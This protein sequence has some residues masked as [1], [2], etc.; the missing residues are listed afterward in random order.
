L[1]T[2]VLDLGPARVQPTGLFLRPIGISLADGLAMLKPF[3]LVCLL[4]APA[5]AQDAPASDAAPPPAPPAA[6]QPLPQPAG[7]P[8]AMMMQPAPMSLSAQAEPAD[9]QNSLYLELGGTSL[10]YSLNYERFL[11]PDFAVRVGF[12]YISVSA[13][14]TSGM[15]TESATAS[16]ATVP[17][18][19]EYL[20]IRSGS[21]S[22]EL[23]AG[24]NFMYMS[25][26]A[27]TFE[28]T[29]SFTGVTAVPAANIGYRYSD[30]KGG[31]VF[32]A[33]YTPLFV[34]TGDDKTVIS[35]FGT[36]F[37]YRF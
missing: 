7:A 33:G 15:S 24:I 14:A 31:F 2:N 12:S 19:G 28:S 18:M 32:R 16:W 23:G 34:V 37:G 30:P 8:P 10:L 3:A 5:L 25:G 22:L 36:S 13:V 26:H 4:V 1:C 21:H 20:G 17:L 35:W 9:K 11:S 29:A 6:A 27:S